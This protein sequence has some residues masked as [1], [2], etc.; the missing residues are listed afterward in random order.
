MRVSKILLFRE[1]YDITR[2]ELGKAC[3]LSPQRIHM[4]EMYQPRIRQE[5]A[6]KLRDG[7]LT[8]VQRRNSRIEEF[9]RDL[10]KHWDTLS[11]FVEE[12]NYEL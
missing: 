10:F 1:K 6:E 4:I 11:E 9:R 7:M 5:T 8:V 3:G 12:N 2:A